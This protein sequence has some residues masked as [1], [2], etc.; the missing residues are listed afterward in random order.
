[1]AGD[2]GDSRLPEA[3]RGSGADV[4]AA[5]R[6]AEGNSAFPKDALVKQRVPPPPP[7]PTRPVR[8]PP[9]KGR[10]HGG[11]L[12]KNCSSRHQAASAGDDQDNLDGSAEAQR[13]ATHHKG[14]SE[15]TA[16]PRDAHA[17]IHLPCQRHQT[18]FHPGGSRVRVGRIVG[19]MRRGGRK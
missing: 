14:T 8:V 19:E 12:L 9:G 11:E 15:M 7:P 13:G 16:A 3:R 5:K 6:G 1:M 4:F 10:Q 17:P 18:S 2:D